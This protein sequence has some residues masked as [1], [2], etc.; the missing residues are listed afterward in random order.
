MFRTFPIRN[1]DDVM[2][3]LGRP[4]TFYRGK[5]EKIKVIGLSQDEKTPMSVR[6]GLMGLVIPTIFTKESLESQGVKLP[7][8]PE[9]RLTYPECVSNA[10]TSAGKHSAVEDLGIILGNPMD[11]YIFERKTYEVV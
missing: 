3:E 11:M 10:L 4:E 6:E 8:P 7:I 9:S 2:A 1:S 5:W